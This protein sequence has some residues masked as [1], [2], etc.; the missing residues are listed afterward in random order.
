MILYKLISRVTFLVLEYIVIFYYIV[1]KLLIYVT[2]GIEILHY[3][4]FWVIKND[5][6]KNIFH[7]FGCLFSENK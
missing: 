5:I 2:I 6:R 7:I 3:E 4:P 1:M